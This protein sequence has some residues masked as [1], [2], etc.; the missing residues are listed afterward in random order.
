M[1]DLVDENVAHIEHFVR[2]HARARELAAML[3]EWAV[4]DPV[5][6]REPL[7]CGR[8]GNHADYVVVGPEWPFCEPCLRAHADQ[9]VDLVVL[10]GWM[11]DRGYSAQNV[12]A[13]VAKP[14]E[15]LREYRCAMAVRDHQEGDHFPRPDGYSDFGWYCDHPQGCA[16]TYEDRGWWS[17]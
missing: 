3:P 7:D 17:W 12:A 9:S 4:L 15:Y 5:P 1:I 6:L 10:T 2:L 13:A 8:C 16:W 14:V 11:A